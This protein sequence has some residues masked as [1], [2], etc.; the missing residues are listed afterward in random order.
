MGYIKSENH[1]INILNKTARDTPGINHK[2]ILKAESYIDFI[3]SKKLTDQF[4][5]DLRENPYLLEEDMLLRWLQQNHST[6]DS[7]IPSGLEHIMTAEFQDEVK[8]LN[9]IPGVYSFWSTSKIPL[10]IGISNNL[11]ERIINSFSERFTKYKKPIYFRYLSTETS[12]DAALLEIYFI[13]KLKPSL[14]RTSKYSD[15]LTIKII[16]EPKFS[17]PILCNRVIGDTDE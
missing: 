13:G 12:M 1:F 14:N 4:T 16:K 6:G 2:K 11:K 9:D 7:Y 5:W 3:Y 15:K 8:Q 17:K 10:Y